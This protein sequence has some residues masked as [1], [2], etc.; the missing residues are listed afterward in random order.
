MRP[1]TVR[2]PIVTRNVLSAT[3]GTCSTRYAASLIDT[4]CRSSGGSVRARCATS[5]II[6]G[7]LPSSTSRSMS[8]GVVAEVRIRDDES[9]AGLIARPTTANGQRSRSQSARKRGEVIRRGSRARSAPALRCTRFR[10]AP[11]P[12]LRRGRRASRSARPRH[13]R[14]RAP[15]THS[16]GRPRRR[17]ESTGSD[18]PRPV[19][20]S[21][22]ST[23]CARRWISALPRCTESKSRSAVFAPVAIDDAAPPPIPISIPGPPSWISSAPS[24]MGSLCACAAAILPTPPA[25]MIGL[26]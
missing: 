19:A 25:I 7:G 9:I 21:G 1:P 6:R 23:S 17:R 16:T 2:S 22:R 10:A 11:C 3:E 15:G 13:R 12:A 26:W 20:S 8:T 5:R 18:S 14:G 4:R 24:G